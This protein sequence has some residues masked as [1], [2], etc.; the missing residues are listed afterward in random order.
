MVSQQYKEV[1]NY[2]RIHKEFEYIKLL[3]DYYEV[4]FYPKLCN[5]SMDYYSYLLRNDLDIL[6]A[7]VGSL[8]NTAEYARVEGAHQK[9][10][11]MSLNKLLGEG[12]DDNG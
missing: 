2:V 8:V 1:C 6:G 3:S 7:K 4:Q 9:K 10:D 12:S 5:Y 11:K